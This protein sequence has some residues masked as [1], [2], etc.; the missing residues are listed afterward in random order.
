MAILKVKAGVAG[1][2]RCDVMTR[3]LHLG[4]FYLTYQMISLEFELFRE[5]FKIVCEFCIVIW[6]SCA[7][8]WGGKE[9]WKWKEKDES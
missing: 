9:N 4:T 3:S 6:K 5:R 7:F 1:Q 8:L 2:E